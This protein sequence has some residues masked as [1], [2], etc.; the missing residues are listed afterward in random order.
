MLHSLDIG[1]ARF[2]ILLVAVV[3]EFVQV[4]VMLNRRLSL[5]LAL[6]GKGLEFLVAVIVFLLDHFGVALRVR[7]IL[8][9]LE[10]EP[11]TL[12]HSDAEGVLTST[13]DFL[14]TV[15]LSLKHLLGLDDS[16]TLVLDQEVVYGVVAIDRVI[17]VKESSVLAGLV[18]VSDALRRVLHQGRI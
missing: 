17:A 3:A 2:V 1:L 14:D 4:L 13:L 18:S 6:L 8:A 11:S 9:L 5:L 15:L 12:L 10:D 16:A 7:L